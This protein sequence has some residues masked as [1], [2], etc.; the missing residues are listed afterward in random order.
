LPGIAGVD[1]YVCGAMDGTASGLKIARVVWGS[2][3]ELRFDRRGVDPVSMSQIFVDPVTAR[4]LLHGYEVQTEGLRFT[5]DNVWLDRFVSG[6]MAEFDADESRRR[7]H[8]SQFF[9]YLIESRCQVLSSSVHDVRLGAALLATAAGHK[10]FGSEVQRLARFWSPAGLGNLFE[11]VRVRLLSQH[12]LMTPARVERAAATLGGSDG[13]RQILN[14]AL[15]ACGQPEH[16]SNYLKSTI[17]HG[18][19]LRLK[20]LVS[21]VGQGDDRKLVA[22]ATLSI[23]FDTDATP[24][25]TVCEAGANGDGTIRGVIDNWSSVLDLARADF[26]GACLNAD[27][28][29]MVE[30]FW[31][32]RQRHSAWRGADPR[33]MAA[34]AAIAREIDPAGARDRLAPALSRIL[35]GQADVEAESFALYEVAADIEG[36]RQR[37]VGEAGRPVVGWELASVAV[38]DAISGAAPILKRLRDAYEALD[39]A[40]EESLASDARLAEQVFRLAAPLCADGCRGCVHQASDLMGD[41][42]TEASVSRSL[43][44]R[45]LASGL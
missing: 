30:R 38:A 32:M 39:P 14:D 6:V 24:V 11:N 12:P 10:T 27:E 42:L 20:Q 18:L 43:L 37:A 7:W 44:Q 16:L 1:A 19:M 17:I 15:R 45:F 13:F 8:K 23:Q 22:H 28:D 33:D 2:T 9:R 41:S 3:A 36:A 4:P 21:L 5:L 40:A 31:Q 25:V 26:L 35:F 29:E 34:I